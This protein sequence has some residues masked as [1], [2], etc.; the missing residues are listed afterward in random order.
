MLY[1]MMSSLINLFGLLLMHIVPVYK[2]YAY[3]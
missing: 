3:L 1:Y 2:S